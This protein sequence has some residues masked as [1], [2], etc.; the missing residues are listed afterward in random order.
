LIA[1]VA[2]GIAALYL[3]GVLG[4]MY[5]S[6]FG[7]SSGPVWTEYFAAVDD[8]FRKGDAE[9]LSEVAKRRGDSVAALWASQSAGDVEL[10]QGGRLLYRERDEAERSLRRAKDHF[11]HVLNAGGRSALLTERARF[12]LAQVHECLSVAATGTK[13][14]LRSHL[15]QAA[16]LYGELAKDSPTE[17]IRQAAERRLRELLT[18][19]G[20]GFYQ[21]L[22]E[23]KPP[24]PADSGKES[25]GASS[26]LEKISQSPD[27]P[28]PAVEQ[29]KAKSP[30]T[31]GKQPA[32]TGAEGR[33][34]D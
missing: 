9:A 15:E 34:K 2:A 20:N 26:N 14:D 3:T 8:G 32:G 33:G 25:A 23:T 1:A 29:E 6:V 13:R 18:L 19:K 16:A 12:G 31:A 22:A 7:S 28:V 27:F 5:S 4:A 24:Q 17:A 10:A 11:E 21:W 30:K